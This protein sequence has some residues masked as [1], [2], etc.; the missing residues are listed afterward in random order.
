[1]SRACRVQHNALDGGV[2][3]VKMGSDVTRI[4]VFDHFIYVP[5]RSS[6]VAGAGMI[7]EPGAHAQF[8]ISGINSFNSAAQN[9]LIA[10]D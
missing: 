2:A 4:K 1:M 6:H 3:N 9:S 10:R 5:H 7:L 8:P